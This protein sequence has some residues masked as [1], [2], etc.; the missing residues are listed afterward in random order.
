LQT[1]QDEDYQS[2]YFVAESFEEA[3]EQIRFVCKFKFL[4]EKY[5]LIIFTVLKK[6]L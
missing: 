6:I 3:K 1:Y 5:I 2:I 4:S